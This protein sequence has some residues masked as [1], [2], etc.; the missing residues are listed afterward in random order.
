MTNI[1]PF[2]TAA[3]GR[4]VDCVTL[5]NGAYTAKVLTRGGILQSLCVP[6]RDGH[7]VDIVLGFD[8]VRAYEEQSCY[9]G[10]LIGR[11]ANRIAG[12]RITVGGRTL[13][14]A[15]NDNGKNHLHGGEDGFD[16]RIWAIA[17]TTENSVTLSLDSPDGDQGYPA[18]LHAEVTYTLSGGSLTLDYA[19]DADALTLCNLTN[20]SY[21][22]LAGHASGAVA[23]QQL[24]IYAEQFTPL[25]KSG[26]PEGETAPA[27]GTALDFRAAH[28][29]GER[30][31]AAC[32]QIQ[33][34]AG[35][36]HN[37]VLGEPCSTRTVA[38][39]DCAETG[40]TLTCA[41]TMPA[42]QLYT[43]NFLPDSLPT[44]K[45]GAQ[46]GRRHGFCLETQFCPNA[47]AFPLLPQ[48]TVSPEAPYRHRTAFRFSCG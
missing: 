13:A 30:W 3:D 8:T 41:S 37:Y 44:G 34:A 12:G 28:A 46:Y 40:I 39:A 24:T 48:P 20:H 18:A 23:A 2:G 21:F 6:D 11:C 27:E 14:L 36:D 42:M 16:K 5:S 1:T 32:P 9:I 31:D 43:G 7:P 22:N 15:C 29:L 38:R 35:Y 19:A 25:G 47:G 26:V 17:Q 33:L 4:A 10:A 45:G